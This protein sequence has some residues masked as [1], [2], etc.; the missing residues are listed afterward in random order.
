MLDNGLFTEREDNTKLIKGNASKYETI[1]LFL[2]PSTANSSGVNLCP[3]SSPACVAAC[4]NTSGRAT[5]FPA[6]LAARRRKSDEFLANREA[7]IERLKAEIVVYQRRAAKHNKHLAVRLNGTSDIDFPRHVFSSFP[8]VQFYDYTKSP[9]RMRKWLKHDG[10]LQA[11]YHLTFSASGENKKE[12]LATLKAGG[13]VAVVFSS[14]NFPRTWEGYKVKTGEE[15]DLRFLDKGP[16]VIGLKAK[17]K[18]RK[19]ASSFVIQI[20]KREANHAVR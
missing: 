8:S 3:F 9:Y 7:F 11:N 14:T 16:V 19:Q 6:I 4:L 2:S 1:A 12:C 13:N 20:D 15:S 17:G 18:A 5:I 10:S